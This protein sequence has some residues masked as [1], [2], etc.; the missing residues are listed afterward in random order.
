ML[1]CAGT[2]GC[3]LISHVIPWYHKKDVPL[4]TVDMAKIHNWRVGPEAIAKVGCI[5]DISQQL[6]S[7]KHTHRNVTQMIGNGWN[8][9]TVGK[10][11]MFA[12][13]SIEFR[14]KAYKL[15]HVPSPTWRESPTKK[16]TSTLEPESKA[17]TLDLGSS[18]EII[19]E[20]RAIWHDPI[21]CK[22]GF[23]PHECA[24]QISCLLTM[25]FSRCSV[26]K[27]QHR[28]E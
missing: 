11:L 20:L 13:S 24:F 8:L 1:V 12:L 9:R 4:T 22:A 14:S 23:S 28:A 15:T 18:L 25:L 6:A 27:S 2:L 3:P 19:G 5:C 17:R 21:I 10:F 16:K 26:Y 7:G